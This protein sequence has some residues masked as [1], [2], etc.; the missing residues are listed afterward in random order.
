[1]PALMVLQV[2][3]TFIFLA[4]AVF[5]MQQLVA[6]LV[7]PT[8]LDGNK[9]TWFRARPMQGGRLSPNQIQ[10][11]LSVLKSV[12]GVTAVSYVSAL[13]LSSINLWQGSL[14]MRPDAMPNDFQSVKLILVSSGSYETLQPRMLRGRWFSEGEYVA[15]D[16]FAGN[17]IP[18]TVVVTHSL[19][20]KLWPNGNPLGQLLYAGHGAP[21]RVIGVVDHYLAPFV[22]SL[23]SAEDVAI[24]PAL[25]AYPGLLVAR[26]STTAD[27]ALVR[28]IQDSLYRV[29]S[30][31]LVTKS[32]VLEE[33]EREYFQDDRKAALTIAVLG[34]ALLTVTGLGLMGMCTYWIHRRSRT[35]GIKRALGATRGY[36]FRYFLIENALVVSCGVLL[37]GPFAVLLNVWLR[38]HYELSVLPAA[39][40]LET[41]A[42]LIIVGQLAVM[43]AALKASTLSPV[44]AIAL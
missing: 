19:A 11:D 39:T 17:G 36:I 27:D 12:S 13:P 18:A 35:I 33:T 16:P 8:G 20:R 15:Y 7:L 14:S 38:T 22:D 28:K 44:S 4:N 1:M 43:A 32:D 34:A 6:K 23:S 25:P 37:G 10:A 2:A 3:L 24:F 30:D 41:S 29:E 5:S 40:I 9:I 42:M 21:A 31:Q 26:S